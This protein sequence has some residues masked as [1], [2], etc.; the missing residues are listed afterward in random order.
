MN[1]LKGKLNGGVELFYRKTT[2]MLNWFN[3]PLSLGYPGYY[4]NIGDMAN[5]GCLKLET[6]LYSC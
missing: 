6:E 4:D 1:C 5:K 2:D 3:V